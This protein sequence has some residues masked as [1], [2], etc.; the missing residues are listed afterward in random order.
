MP[1]RRTIHLPW[2]LLLSACG[3]AT[4]V[5]VEASSLGGATV[6]YVGDRFEGPLLEPLRLGTLDGAGRGSFDVPPL[7][8]DEIELRFERDG[9][10]ASAP[11]IC[12]PP[13]VEPEPID[14][15]RYLLR[16]SRAT[17]E[18]FLVALEIDQG[19]RTVRGS[20]DPELFDD[21]PCGPWAAEP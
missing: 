14:R 7:D 19:G 18:C 16:R 6:T 3:P 20:Y 17:G 4:T 5:E 13:I 8:T 12:L 10:T 15:A 1:G 9:R 2:L 11:A 21:A